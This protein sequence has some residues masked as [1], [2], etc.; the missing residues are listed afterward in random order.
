MFL[1]S[2]VLLFQAPA[3][4]VVDASAMADRARATQ[5]VAANSDERTPLTAFQPTPTFG[6][7]AGNTSQFDKDGVRLIDLNDPSQVNFAKNG[8]SFPDETSKILSAVHIPTP[9]VKLPPLPEQKPFALRAAHSWLMLALM[10]SGAAT[11]DA[12]STNRAIAEGHEELNPLLR[13]FA[14]TRA[15]YAAVQVE[16]L[17]LDLLARKMQHS[18]NGF[19]RRAWWLPQSIGTSASFSSGIRNLVVAH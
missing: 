15:M 3:I 19:L 8:A 17:L 10:Q 7:P 13:P 2:V 6:T 11:L 12:W 1:A 14:G 5:L 9:P 18:E 4:P 16:P